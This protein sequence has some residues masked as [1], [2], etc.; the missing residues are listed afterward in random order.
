MTLHISGSL[1]ANHQEFLD[2]HGIGT[3]YAVLTIVA[4]SFMVA[5]IIKTV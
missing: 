3:F 2:V 5:T 1:S 4:T